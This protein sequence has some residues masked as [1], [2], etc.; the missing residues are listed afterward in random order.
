[1]AFYKE[2]ESPNFHGYPTP[3]PNAVGFLQKSPS[4][5]KPSGQGFVHRQQPK[6][7]KPS[8]HLG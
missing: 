1:V 3:R 7:T 5:L 2:N 6:L 4:S 8:A